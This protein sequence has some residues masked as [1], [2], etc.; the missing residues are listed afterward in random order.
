APSPLSL[1]DA[2]PISHSPPLTRSRTPPLRGVA[3]ITSNADHCGASNSPRTYSAPLGTS[4]R[5]RATSVRVIGTWV[6]LRARCHLL[7]RSLESEAVDGIGREWVE[8]SIVGFHGGRVLVSGLPHYFGKRR[9]S[10]ERL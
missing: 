3:R 7:K 8:A 2:L 6:S 4:A 1:H 5:N 10:P 9:A